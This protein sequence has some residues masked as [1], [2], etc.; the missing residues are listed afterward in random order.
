MR[1]TARYNLGDGDTNKILYI[2]INRLNLFH[3]INT[4][5]IFTNKTPIDNVNPSTDI[6]VVFVE[7]AI[8]VGLFSTI[9]MLLASSLVRMSYGI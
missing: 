4:C 2:S 1:V 7:A 3:F 6:F 5:R 8:T 9:F